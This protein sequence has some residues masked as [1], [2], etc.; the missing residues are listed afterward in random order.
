MQVSRA[1]G[2]PDGYCHVN[3]SEDIFCIRTS[4][5]I[6]ANHLPTMMQMRIQGTDSD[7][8]GFP[9]KNIAIEFDPTWL[10]DFPA[11]D[12]DMRAENSPRGLFLLL[13][14]LRQAPNI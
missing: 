4:R 10:I 12:S 7:G 3:G 14:Q 9:I 5:R 11:T 2:R 13:L 8:L 6:F 1:D